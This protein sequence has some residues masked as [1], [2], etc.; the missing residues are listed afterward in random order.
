MDHRTWGRIARDRLVPRLPGTW[1]VVANH[2]VRTPTPYLG[3]YLTRQVTKGGGFHLDAVVQPLWRHATVLVGT[4]AHRVA[5]PGSAGDSYVTAEQAD[6]IAADPDLV[7]PL[8]DLVVADALPFLTEHGSGVRGYVALLDRAVAGMSGPSLVHPL[9]ELA[10]AHVL[11]GDADAARSSYD[12][13]VRAG[14]GRDAPLWASE[15]AA[16]ARALLARSDADLLALV[17]ELRGT[18]AA[19][20]LRWKLPEPEGPDPDVD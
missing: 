5:R 1:L 20:R 13:V 15:P 12:G 4:Y 11:L 16:A 3:W 8:V 6:A 14:A 17:G 19:M 2:V 9:T 18:A 7:I 10:E